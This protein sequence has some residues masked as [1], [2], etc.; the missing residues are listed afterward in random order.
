MTSL[1]HDYTPFSS[2]YAQRPDYAPGVVDGLVRI[3]GAGPDDRVCDI[4]AGSG[5]LTVP[6]LDSGLIVDAVEPNAAMREIGMGRTAGFPRVAWHEGFGESTGRAA[7]V[8]R[9]VTFGSSFDRTERAAALQEA[10]RILRPGGYFACLWNHRDLNDPLQ[11]Q[12]E[13]LIHR[14]VPDYDY[15]PRRQDPS[16]VIRA[17]GLFEEPLALQQRVVHPV[18]AE[19]WCDAWSS[20]MTLGTQAGDRFGDVLDGIRTLVRAHAG[21]VVEVPYTTRLWIARAR[22]DRGDRGDRGGRG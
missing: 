1:K 17:S 8:Y 19:S 20:H 14:Q 10:D 5:H 22:S 6:L 15:G 13:A 16:P 21:G 18:D 2:T 7:G 9:L 11:A 12:I 3:A 4:G